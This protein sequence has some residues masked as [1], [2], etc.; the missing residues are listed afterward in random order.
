VTEPTGW[1]FGGWNPPLRGKP[2][3]DRLKLRNQSD[4]QNSRELEL[5]R[6]A[7]HLICADLLLDG[8]AAYPTAQGMP[9][10]LVV[11]I[12]ARLIRLQVKSTFYPKNPQPNARATPAYFFSIRRAGRGGGRVYRANE[13]D[14]Y[15]LVALD[16]RLIAYFATV[17]LPKQSAVIR[18]PG[19][20]Y[21]GGP[22]PD[23]QFETATF[24][25]MIEILQHQEIA[26][27]A[28]TAEQ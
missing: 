23:R 2:H 27:H 15:A 18:V 6:A 12:G 17:E 20:R 24:A 16:R 5:G 19:A 25:H 28:H 8:W 26:K 11:D 3:D 7:E 22:T 9:Y 13:F 21:G 1:L 4:R 10:D 14:A